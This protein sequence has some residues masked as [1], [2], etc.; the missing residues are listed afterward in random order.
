[1]IKLTDDVRRVLKDGLRE[2]CSDREIYFRL[3][4]PTGERVML[5]LDLKKDNDMVVEDDGA[6]LLLIERSVASSLDGVTLSIRETELG[7]TL[8]VDRRTP[9]LT[10]TTARFPELTRASAC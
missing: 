2:Y 3:V 9:I 1:M 5:M 7:P 10:Q 8:V 4:Q 6:M